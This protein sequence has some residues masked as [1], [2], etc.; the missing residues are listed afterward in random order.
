MWNLRCVITISI[1]SQESFR[2]IFPRR[3]TKFPLLPLVRSFPSL[4]S[5]WC[6]CFP[7]YY[8][9]VNQAIAHGRI[10][11]FECFSCW[12]PR[13]NFLFIL[14]KFSKFLVISSRSPF[15]SRCG[16]ENRNFLWKFQIP[17]DVV[18]LRFVTMEEKENPSN[19]CAERSN[20]ES[21]NAELSTYIS[22]HFP[23]SSSAHDI[24]EFSRKNL[25]SLFLLHWCRPRRIWR[26]G[27]NVERCFD[28]WN[29]GDSKDYLRR[30]WVVSLRDHLFHFHSSHPHTQR[31][32]D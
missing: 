15:S 12:R 23:T 27:K 14:A 1:R 8:F 18:L 3:D 11:S 25:H 2:R 21:I 10:E 9:L 7:T 29:E 16:R 31:A 19:C 24:C 28:W 6:G 13:R 32:Q 30:S 5:R 22:I 17:H 4:F 26:V 20:R